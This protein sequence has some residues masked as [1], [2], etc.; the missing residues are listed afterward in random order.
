MSEYIKRYGKILG[1]VIAVLAIF[2]LLGWGAV[3]GYNQITVAN[4][5]ASTV[6]AAV[7]PLTVISVENAILSTV[8]AVSN[9]GDALD[10]EWEEAHDFSNGTGGANNT[11]DAWTYNTYTGNFLTKK[12]T[13]IVGTTSDSSKINNTGTAVVGLRLVSEVRYDYD[14]AGRVWRTRQIAIL[15]DSG[16]GESLASDDDKITLT[17]Y[18][19]VNGDDG[20]VTKTVVKGYDPVTGNPCSTESAIQSGDL[21]TTNYY[22]DNGRM[23]TVIDAK[24]YGTYYTYTV[25][26]QR[27][28]V[29]R[30]V[31][32]S[33]DT[34]PAGVI[35]KDDFASEHPLFEKTLMVV[36]D[37]DYDDAGRVEKSINALSHY[38]TM[39]YD[40]RGRVTETIAWENDTTDVEMLQT[41]KEYDNLGRVLKDVVMADADST[42]APVV[43][44][45][46]VTEYAYF[47][48]TGDHPGL[49]NT[50]KTYNNNSA[51]ALT[52]TYDYD[53]MGRREKTTAPDDSETHIVYNAAGNVVRRW[54]KEE[55]T[56][57]SQKVYTVMDYLYN[58]YGQ[59]KEQRHV[60]LDTSYFFH[61]MLEAGE[62]PLPGVAGYPTESTDGM[63]G[64]IATYFDYNGL[65]QLEM[66]TD[67]K[68]TE[69]TYA[70][71]WLGQK[72]QTVED[73]GGL[74]RTTDYGYDRLGRQN[75]IIGYADGS[76]EQETEYAYSKLGQIET[77]T[78]PDTETIEYAYNPTGQV[79]ERTD[80]L[81]IVTDYEYSAAGNLLIKTVVDFDF[82][83]DSTLDDDIIET[84]TY[85][86]LGRMLTA[87]K[88]ANLNGSTP[89]IDIS[90]S[91]FGDYTSL[92]AAESINDQ[93]FLDQTGEDSSYTHDQ[94]GNLTQITYP[95]DTVV[96][97]TV[98]KR[99]R[100]D[101]IKE[102]TDTL[103]SY[104]YVG[105]RVGLRVYDETDDTDPAAYSVEYDDYGRGENH[106]T[107]QDE[108]N[109][110][111]F[112]YTYDLNNNIAD[113][114]FDHRPSTPD[115]EF[116]YDDLN[117]LT[118]VE[119][120]DDNTD[121]EIFTMDDLGNRINATLRG[122]NQTTY[123]VD[124]GTNRYN[125]SE[126]T[127]D[128]ELEYDAAG[129]TTVD[130][131]GYQYIY[132]YE[133]RLRF[134][135]DSGNASVAYYEYDALGRR[136]FKRDII[137][138]QTD[139]LYYYYNAD[140]Q[141]LQEVLQEGFERSFGN[142]YVYGNYIDEV[143][144]MDDATDYFYY[145]H[146]HLFSPVALLGATGAV[147]ERYEYNAYGKVTVLTDSDDD[148]NWFDDP[149]DTIY[150]ASQ[151]GNP[152]L[153]TGRRLDTFADNGN[154]EIMYYRNR[155]YNT[156]T[157]RFL[158]NDPL[159]VVPN[160]S[161]PNNFAPMHQYKDGMNVYCYVKSKVVSL[162]DPYGLRAGGSGFDL[163]LRIQECKRWCTRTYRGWGRI[164]CKMKCQS[165]ILGEGGL[166]LP[167]HLQFGFSGSIAYYVPF[168]GNK[169]A[170]IKITGSKTYGTCCDKDTKEKKKYE[171]WSTKVT[172]GVYTGTWGFRPRL[173]APVV[174][175]IKDCPE[176]KSWDCD[177]VISISA[178]VSL[179]HGK[180]D[181]VIGSGW[182]CS[183][184]IRLNIEDIKSVRFSIGGGGICTKTKVY[185]NPPVHR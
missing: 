25:I 144:I 78:Y 143:L 177:F 114:S 183:G 39:D 158:T 161:K 176:K 118:N 9:D 64:Y 26:G 175:N 97:R 181:Y 154:Y 128:I 18:G 160:P 105:S 63:T 89:I 80:Q 51:T 14:E 98:D 117:R 74:A 127:F 171:K 68:G 53:E 11:G 148:D 119:Y 85:D 38:T 48:S 37:T 7:S 163:P 72:S 122:E 108:T 131:N 36:S 168:G 5:I 140:W 6:P 149:G 133:N 55:N 60:P 141:V 16:S 4:T 106:H 110:A 71:N 99:G 29:Y 69:T 77:I 153:F 113:I 126:G 152:Y 138:S 93:Y 142:R 58:Q 115:N 94:A 169:G 45:D 124:V 66:M 101:E 59:V 164:G 81:D 139:A 76:T 13:F 179:L 129:N 95:D 116:I 32:D 182:S 52:T 88:K 147:V 57:L 173:T 21:V 73:F 157:G 134:V 42:S 41:R 67:A 19:T 24:D 96:T 40:S 47:S 50:V 109:I 8:L 159:G 54:T 172:T 100:I 75:S 56:S 31:D 22:Y 178:R 46:K 79:K 87:V 112:G 170:F 121:I 145:A 44:V 83:L 111:D 65:G 35:T 150:A 1:S 86:A 49:L 3:W 156:Y 20:K 62:Y 125:E 107:Y 34:T 132:D 43:T 12:Q 33:V 61:Y 174:A 120:L 103:V 135:K 136:I 137:A 155:Y 28:L 166:T 151:L 91:T 27:D 70:Y 162:Y 104:D 15:N 165:H 90:T 102:S 2:V 146:N 17:V 123:A 82:D 185:E 10:D 130:E 23:E 180:C 84:F 30:E 167:R 184:G 92:G